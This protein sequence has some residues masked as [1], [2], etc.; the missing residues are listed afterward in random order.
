MTD[1]T[2]EEWRKELKVLLDHIE[3]HPSADLT[4]QRARV[5][6]L[7]QLLADHEKSSAG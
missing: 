3:H 1:S 5:A 7:R 2:A 6:V 4:E